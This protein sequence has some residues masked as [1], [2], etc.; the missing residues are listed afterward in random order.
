M[1]LETEEMIQC[2]R[3][4]KTEEAF[5]LLQEAGVVVKVA[6]SSQPHTIIIDYF[7]IISNEDGMVNVKIDGTDITKYVRSVHVSYHTED[8]PDIVLSLKAKPM[9]LEIKE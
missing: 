6:T 2:I 3:Q 4:A 5:Q 1:A 8:Y 7:E 9:I